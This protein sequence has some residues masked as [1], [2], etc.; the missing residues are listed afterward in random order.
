MVGTRSLA[1]FLKGVSVKFYNPTYSSSQR[2]SAEDLMA[3][4]RCVR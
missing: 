3:Y 4:C 1:K 2:L